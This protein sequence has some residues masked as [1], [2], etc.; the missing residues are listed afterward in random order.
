MRDPSI[1]NVDELTATEAA[2]ELDRLASEIWRHDRLYYLDSTPNITDAAYDE[3]RRRNQ[4]IEARFSHLKR[5]D[6]PS[7]RVGAPPAEGFAK[8]EHGTPMLSLDNAFDSDDVTEFFARVSRFLGLNSEEPI[9]VVGEPKIDGISASVRY[10]YGNL[11]VGAT[12]GDGSVGENITDNLRTVRDLPL[13]LD[14]TEVP[15]ILE[16]RGEVYLGRKDFFALNASRENDGEA[17]FA[18]PRNAAAGSLRQLDSRIT[19]GRGLH[20]FAYT[21]GEVSSMPA[22]T[23]WEFLKR[24]NEWGFQTNPLA[25]LCAGPED[26]LALFFSDPGDGDTVRLSAQ[27]DTLGGGAVRYGQLDGGTVHVFRPPSGRSSA[28]SMPATTAR[29]PSSCKRRSRRTRP[30]ASGR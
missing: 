24:L 17:L 5:T 9:N 25:R 2:S 20:F 13:R 21:W 15:D 8:V 19:A 14:G 18:N 22:R 29:S 3:L 23:Q 12:R 4:M 10:E 6:S 1:H 30:T 27:S 28:G 16:I 11:V 26:V 7:L